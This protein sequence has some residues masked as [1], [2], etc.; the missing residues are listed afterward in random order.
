[1]K[2]STEQVKAVLT[3]SH[4]PTPDTQDVDMA[5]LKLMDADLIQQVTRDVIEMSDREAVIEDLKARIKAGTYNPTGA[6]IADTMVRRA[7]ADSIKA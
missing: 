7:I 1:V 3:A 4:T 6:E 5:V 2:I